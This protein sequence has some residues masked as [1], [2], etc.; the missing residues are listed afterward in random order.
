[1]YGWMAIVRFAIF[2]RELPNDTPVFWFLMQIAMF[3][4]FVTSYPV[5]WWLLRRGVKER[6]YRGQRD[7][8]RRRGD[9][10]N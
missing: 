7:G 8:L 2:D 3:F 4:G 5:N 1:M 10:A 9:N 6:K